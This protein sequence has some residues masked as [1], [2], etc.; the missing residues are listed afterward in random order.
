M[1]PPATATRS[2]LPATVTLEAAPC[3]E[4]CALAADEPPLPCDDCWLE[5]DDAWLDALEFCEAW[6][7]CAEPP[8]DCADRSD[9][10]EFIELFALLPEDMPDCPDDCPELFVIIGA[11]THPNANTRARLR[12]ERMRARMTPSGAPRN[13]GR[14]CHLSGRFSDA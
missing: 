5:A 7:D 14:S 1:M 10:P 9:V 6:L 8:D 3:A 11:R 2:T 12:N 4:V 13:R